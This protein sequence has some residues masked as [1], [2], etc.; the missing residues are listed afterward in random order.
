MNGRMNTRI[1]HIVLVLF[2]LAAFGIANGVHAQDTVC[3]KRMERLQAV[4][5]TVQ[6]RQYFI[7]RGR[8]DGCLYPYYSD[9]EYVWVNRP[10][11]ELYFPEITRE[12]Y[13]DGKYWD[14]WWR[15]PQS[16]DVEDIDGQKV[17]K[18]NDKNED[19]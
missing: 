18:D 9:I 13:F 16:V 12:G 3:R 11:S 17:I 14:E 4:P 5:D 8:C 19:L 2:L 10:L 1:R 7:I 6:K 15:L